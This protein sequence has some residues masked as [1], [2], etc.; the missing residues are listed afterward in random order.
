LAARRGSGWRHS[1]FPRHRHRRR[2]SQTGDKGCPRRDRRGFPAR[3]R[4]TR[5]GTIAA[6]R[7]AHPPCHPGRSGDPPPRWLESRWP[8]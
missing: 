2:A 7:G 6:A 3:S 1:P 8:P 4:V 5:Q